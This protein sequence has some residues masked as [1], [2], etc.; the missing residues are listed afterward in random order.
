MAYPQTMLDQF[1]YLHQQG[2]TYVQMSEQLG[3]DYATLHSWKNRLGLPS[4]KPGSR[5]DAH[6]N[7]KNLKG[8]ILRGESCHF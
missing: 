1:A 8:Q 5:L 6:P 2:M 4:R 3:V 7:F